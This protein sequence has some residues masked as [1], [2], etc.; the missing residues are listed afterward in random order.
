MAMDE[1]YLK[2]E[3]QNEV[4][5]FTNVRDDN[6]VNIALY[7][8]G[9]YSKKPSAWQRIK[10]AWYH[11]ITGKIYADA[12]VINHEQAE[13]LAE[14]ILKVRQSHPERSGNQIPERI[15]NTI[16]KSPEHRS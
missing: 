5:V 2:C 15:P 13:Q 10:F 4:L 11:L 1:F 6:H 3:C 12:V 9:Y 14:W 7:S 8:H 16:H